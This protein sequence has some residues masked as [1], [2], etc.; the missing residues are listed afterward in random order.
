MRLPQKSALAFWVPLLICLLLSVVVVRLFGIR[1]VQIE[2]AEV[3]NL[4]ADK[5]NAFRQALWLRL[6]HLETLNMLLRLHNG[7]PIHFADAAQGMRRLSSKSSILLAPG[8]IVSR[9]WPV[10]QEARYVGLNLLKDPTLQRL[11]HAGKT[12]SLSGPFPLS[13]DQSVLYGYKLVYLPG[14]DGQEVFWGILAFYL[15][16]EDVLREAGLDAPSVLG[17]TIRLVRDDGIAESP[18]FAQTSRNGEFDRHRPGNATLPGSGNVLEYAF[19]TAGAWWALWA[20]PVGMWWKNASVWPLALG[21]LVGSLLVA[22][23]SR[24]VCVLH[25]TRRALEQLLNHDALTGALNR[26]GLFRAL[27]GKDQA[28]GRRSFLA[29]VDLNKFKRVNDTYGHE[30][31]DKVLQAFVRAVHLHVDEDCVLARI[32]GD[33]FVILFPVGTALAQAKRVIAAI[34]RTFAE[35]LELRSGDELCCD[36]A[37]GLVFWPEREENFQAVLHRADI[38]MYRDKHRK[39]REHRDI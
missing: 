26:H 5:A 23:L 22:L 16:F 38:A 29:Y 25:M 2:R 35:P 17:R 10:E 39:T 4:L 12:I 8:G 11:I 28:V 27:A 13:E 20:Y 31:G 14:K 15:S 34:R 9:A 18:V 21:C 37:C 33:E 24:Q 7:L 1:A 19:D 3:E 36:F 30:A 6:Y 32:G